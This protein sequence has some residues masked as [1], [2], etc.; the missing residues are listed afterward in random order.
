VNQPKNARVATNQ[1]GGT[2]SHGV[3]LA[4][5]QNPHI[6]FEPSIHDGLH[7]ARRPAPNNPPEVR[8]QLVQSVIERRNDYVQARA[9]YVTMQEWERNDLVKNLGDLLGQCERDVQ[10]R[11]LWHL[12]LV[13]DDYG[14]RVGKAIKLGAADVKHLAPLAGQILTSEDT[15]RLGRLGQNGDTLDA[16]PWGK[17]TGSVPTHQATAADVLGGMRAVEMA[18]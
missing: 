13:H 11:M 5:G 7:E 12:F 15:A 1:R 18:K 9:R 4:P 10:E 8:G 2:L 16:K 17:W 6:N 14:T 3:D